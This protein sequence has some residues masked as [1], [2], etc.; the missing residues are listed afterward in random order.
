MEIYFDIYWTFKWAAIS[1]LVANIT[2]K[3]KI[4]LYLNNC[5][6]QHLYVYQAGKMSYILFEIT[7]RTH[8]GTE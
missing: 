3:T 7:E 5:I 4:V 1:E 6:I 2:A 8:T